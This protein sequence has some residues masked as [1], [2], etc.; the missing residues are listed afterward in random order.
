MP[1]QPRSFPGS[2]GGRNAEI[3]LE[4][5]VSVSRE[6]EALEGEAL[7]TLPPPWAPQQDCGAHSWEGRNLGPQTQLLTDIHTRVFSLPS[8]ILHPF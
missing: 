5:A 7:R 3:T 6:G 1:P 4:P 8:D 2:Q